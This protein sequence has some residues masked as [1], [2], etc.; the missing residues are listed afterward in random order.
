MKKIKKEDIISVR[1]RIGVVTIPEDVAFYGNEDLV[2]RCLD[3]VSFSSSDKEEEILLIRG[4]GRSHYEVIQ[5]AKEMGLKRPTLETVF[6]FRKKISF[7]EQLRIAQYI[8]FPHEPVEGRYLVVGYQDDG[9]GGKRIVEDVTAKNEDRWAL[10]VRYAF[11][12]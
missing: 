8:I 3:S 9:E 12:R 6:A 7:T 1:V 5:A 10:S 11:V 2:K 4:E